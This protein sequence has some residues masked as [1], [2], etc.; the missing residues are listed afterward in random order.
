MSISVGTK[1]L[2]E[3]G[4]KSK[5]K[6]KVNVMNGNEEKC[7]SKVDSSNSNYLK[8][9]MPRFFYLLIFLFSFFN[10]TKRNLRILK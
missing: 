7:Q 9:K 10:E 5:A 4:V 6:C 2:D 8:K 3:P 1:S